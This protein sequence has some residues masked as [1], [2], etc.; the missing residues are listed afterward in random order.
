MQPEISTRSFP[1]SQQSQVAKW[2]IQH[3]MAALLVSLLPV[4]AGYSADEPPIFADRFEGFEQKVVFP[5]TT[6]EFDLSILAAPADPQDFEFSALPLPLPENAE[7]TDGTLV[8]RPAIDQIGQFEF[9]LSARAPN[10]AIKS[11]RAFVTVLE[12]PADAP[13][14]FSGRL[15]DA[16]AMSQG[17]EVPIVGATV[18]SLGGSAVT[19][20]DSAGNF[21]LEGVSA[22]SF[23][24]DVDSSTAADGPEN[25]VYASFRE[26]FDLVPRVVNVIDR[27]IYLPRIDPDSLTPIDPGNDTVVVNPNLDVAIDIPPGAADNPD[28]SDF[29]GE[30]SIS[31]V[32]REFAPMQLPRELDPAMLLTIQP[33]GVRFDQPVPIV[34]PEHRQPG[35]EQRDRH[36]LTGPGY[37]RIQNCRARTSQQRRQHD[38]NHLRRR[39]LGKLA[40]RRC[41]GRRRR[42]QRCPTIILRSRRRNRKR[43]VASAPASA[44]RAG[45]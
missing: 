9:L 6:V 5:G 41:R 12:P 21:L 40:L 38:R 3:V 24:L 29:T 15:L 31:D 7:L 13:T 37:R 14:S 20:T 36:L 42:A 43:S 30:M 16:N 8:F 25:A 39:S 23:V 18:A 44:C 27:P 1:A 33:T 11:S 4:V 35:A 22:A 26:P 10:G 19:V 34:F 2:K 32:P 17:S 28:G 45:A